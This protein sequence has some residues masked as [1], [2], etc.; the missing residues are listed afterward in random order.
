MKYLKI[1]EGI[2]EHGRDWGYPEQKRVVYSSPESLA[3]NYGTQKNE[4]YFKLEELDPT[5]LRQMVKQEKEKIEEKD[6]EIK[7]ARL[8]SKMANMQEELDKLE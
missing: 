3:R 8:Q 7:K 4:R 1:Y 5:E 6:K 2:V